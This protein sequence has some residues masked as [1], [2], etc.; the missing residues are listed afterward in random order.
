MTMPCSSCQELEQLREEHSI[1]ETERGRAEATGKHEAS[2]VSTLIQVAAHPVPEMSCEAAEE[3][4]ASLQKQLAA[5][6]VDY[7]EFRLYHLS[8]HNASQLACTWPR[9]DKYAGPSSDLTAIC[10]RRPHPCEYPQAWDPRP[11]NIS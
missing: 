6:K 9:P 5:T 3:N 10:K 11:K 7:K 8:P 2:F 1:K 4:L